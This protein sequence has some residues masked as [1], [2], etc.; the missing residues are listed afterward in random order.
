M[1]E[2]VQVPAAFAAAFAA[3]AEH[4]GLAGAERDS[5]RAAVRADLAAGAEGWSDFV[6]TTAD[7]LRRCRARWGRYPDPAAIEATAAALGLTSARWLRSSGPSLLADA[8][9][10]IATARGL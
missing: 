1:S 10:R 7:L 5:F 4:M 2:P 3:V 6:V 8:L 9:D